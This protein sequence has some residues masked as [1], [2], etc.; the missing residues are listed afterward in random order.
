MQAEMERVEQLRSFELDAVRAA[1]GHGPV[2][3]I[4]EA[5]RGPLAGPV[6]AAA[7]ILPEDL[8]LPWLNDSK[9]VTQKRRE[10]FYHQITEQALA[11]AVVMVSPERI[12]EINILQATYE[13]MRGAVSRLSVRPGVLV[14]DAVTIPDMD[15]LQVP[16]IKG[17]ARCISVAAASIL[18]KVTRDAYMEEMDRQYPV[19]GF[20]GHKG[21]GTKAHCA[22]ILQ[23]GP[24]PIHRMSFLGKILAGSSWEKKYP[25]DDENNP[26]ARETGRIGEEEAVRFLEKKGVRI[27]ERNF[28]SRQGE[29]DIIAA[30]D[31]MIIFAEVKYR[32]DLHFG[33]PAEAVGPA[34][35]KSICKTALYYLHRKGLT[36]QTPVR[37]DVLAVTLQGI[38]WIKDAFP[39]CAEP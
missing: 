1:G 5:G 39:F 23:N 13:A 26:S 30:Q 12:D 17:D 31:E 25:Q 7:V 20:A 28:R 9:K 35:Q 34:K 38:R 16:V 33:D 36:T 10:L 22:A 19:Y 15:I 37:F 14:N 27:L 21:Y 2:C 6:A 11:W 29:I 8:V 24:C 4:D 18:A 32:R 3:G